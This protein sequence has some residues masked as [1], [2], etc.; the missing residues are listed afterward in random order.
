MYFIVCGIIVHIGTFFEGFSLNVRITDY[1]DFSGWGG[2]ER[3]RLGMWVWGNYCWVR[4]ETWYRLISTMDM[5]QGRDAIHCVS[6][7]PAHKKRHPAP[8]CGIPLSGNG[9]IARDPGSEPPPI[10]WGH[11]GMTIFFVGRV[12]RGCGWGVDVLGKLLLG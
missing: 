6:T 11:G 1:T 10:N 5:V 9:I 3:E 8:R 12:L 4:Q 2:F 7:Y